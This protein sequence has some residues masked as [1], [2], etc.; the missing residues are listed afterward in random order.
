MSQ[1]DGA[2]LRTLLTLWAGK[3]ASSYA[4]VIVLRHEWSW[5]MTQRQMCVVAWKGT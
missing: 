1:E 3:S 2:C 5:H 4:V